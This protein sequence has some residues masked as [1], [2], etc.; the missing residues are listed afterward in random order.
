MAQSISPPE[1]ENFVILHL[2]SDIEKVKVKVEERQKRAHK[3]K[4]ALLG[5]EKEVKIYLLLNC[6][7]SISKESMLCQT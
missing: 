2:F 7:P 1:I 4:A 5:K 3:Q 6:F